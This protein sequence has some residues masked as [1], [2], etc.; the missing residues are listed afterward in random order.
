MRFSLFLIVFLLHTSNAFA[1]FEIGSGTNSYTAG[2]YVP[3][4][5]LSYATPDQ[6]FAVSTTGVKN[7]Y[8]YQSSYLV[9]YFRSWNVGT[10]WGGNMSTG[11]GGAAGYS[12]RSF[13]DKGSTVSSDTSDFIIGPTF[14]MHLSYGFFFINMSSLLG[15]RDLSNHIT[16]LTFQDVESFSIGVQF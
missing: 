10:F 15:L 1:D 16:G 6:V 4:I 8:Y 14:R 13:Q 3:S 9:A 12:V 2:R 11:F 5:D 7:S